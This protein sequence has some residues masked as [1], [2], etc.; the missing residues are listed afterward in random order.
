M[1]ANAVLG[2]APV[3][4][5]TVSLQGQDTPRLSGAPV[6]AWAGPLQAVFQ[7]PTARP[8]GP[9]H[10]AWPSLAAPGMTASA[11]D[12]SQYSAGTG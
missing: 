5:G 11:A 10:G 9:S 3:Q 4:S 2:L 6:A 12:V 7:N 8:R 1:L